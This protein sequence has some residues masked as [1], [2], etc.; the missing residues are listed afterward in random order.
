VFVTRQSMNLVLRGLQDRGLITRP[1]T[2]ASTAVRV[3]EQRM[4][5][6][7]STT[8]QERLQQDLNTCVDALTPPDES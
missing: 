6:P 8:Q 4:L 1:V 3:V 5:A 7:F 2:A